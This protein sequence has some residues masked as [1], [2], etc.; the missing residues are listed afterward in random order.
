MDFGRK[1]VKKCTHR[2][3]VCTQMHPGGIGKIKTY[4]KL[5]DIINLKVNKNIMLV[6][7]D[8]L[9]IEVGVYMQKFSFKSLKPYILLVF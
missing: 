7:M 4:E 1:I 3:F 5:N 2:Y 9:L 6:I 8:I